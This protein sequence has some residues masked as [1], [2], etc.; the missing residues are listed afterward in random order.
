[1]SA[2]LNAAEYLKEQYAFCREESTFPLRK[3]IYAMQCRPYA[4]EPDLRDTCS[5]IGIY[6]SV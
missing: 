5:G 6:D 1:M 2:N 4:E 3:A